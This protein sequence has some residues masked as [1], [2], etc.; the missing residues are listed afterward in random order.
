MSAQNVAQLNPD[1]SSFQ[2]YLD[3]Y[4][5]EKYQESFSDVDA[6]G[7]HQLTLLVDGITC[8]GCVRSIEKK[9]ATLDGLESAVV[10]ATTKRAELSWNPD[11][12]KLSE[13]IAAFYHIG[14]PAFPFDARDRQKK[15]EK[16]RKQGLQRLGVSLLL[17]AQ[18]MM[19]TVALYVGKDSGITAQNTF[20]FQCVCLLL[21]IP[22]MAYCAVPFFRN[23][24]RALK[25]HHMGMDVP[26]SLALIV[27]F[28]ASCWALYTRIGDVY[29]ES[30]AMF[31]SL[32]LLSRFLELNARI[33]V[34]S[35]FDDIA[36][37]VPKITQRYNDD[38]VLESVTLTALRPGD[39]IVIKAGEIAPVD[40]EVLSGSTAMDEAVLSGESEP[41]LK[42]RGDKVLGGSV[43][44]QS[45]IELL[46]EQ[47]SE[48][49]FVSEILRLTQRAQGLKPRATVVADR[50]SGW[51]ISGVL[52]IAGCVAVYW[53][54]TDPARVIPV[55][56][57]VLV[58]TCPC[59]LAL[60]T[61]AAMI[62]A[63]GKLLKNGIALINPRVLET[64]NDASV[65]VFDKTGTLTS[66]NLKLANFRAC[67][68]L[69]GKL[70][71]EIAAALSQH[72]EHN[73]G[74][75]LRDLE[76]TNLIASQVTNVP[77]FGIHGSVNDKTYWLGS[78][79]FIREQTDVTAEQLRSV[80]DDTQKA[81]YL[82][83]KNELLAI[84]EFTDELQRGAQTLINEL[85]ANDVEV[86]I[87]SGDSE[88]IT[89]RLGEQL[90]IENATGGLKPAEKLAELQRIRD[91]GRVPVVIGD[92]INDAP[93]LAQG[94]I[95]IAVRNATD[96]AKRNADLILLRD[97]L[98]SISQCM[99]ISR[100]TLTIIRQNIIWAVMYNACA[101][102]LAILGLVQPWIAALGMSLSSLI[103][104]VNATRVRAK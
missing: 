98:T 76:A 77:G 50:L 71:R 22:L 14:Y 85:Q 2:L 102:P 18:I 20:Y 13:I 83:S 63:S 53:F 70:T 24:W 1:D 33:R 81:S 84:F 40:G 46:V 39:R 57:A 45:P 99:H 28:V 27:A 4:D 64:L 26:V 42:T 73:V 16:E 21:S 90:G 66:G 89:Q 82:A 61:P 74:V 6:A 17:S 34:T 68:A 97:D 3:A 95:S 69:D 67:G 91:A 100:R 80:G 54:N 104:V 32:L 59:A 48:D 8:A 60:A 10:N 11:R 87:L 52:V 9:L 65:F 72:S 12:L 29:F 101:L 94:T 19:F 51:F 93:M 75:A 88:K 49:S 55:T 15:L 78:L 92:G 25:N 23:A 36:R 38:G 96:L 56:I 44:K 37:A 58:I 41:V 62:V 31:V 86:R 7:N 30:I 43:N 5:D 103:V 47:I 79:E 35:L